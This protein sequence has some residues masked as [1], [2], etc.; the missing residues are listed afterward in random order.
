MCSNTLIKCWRPPTE[1]D[2]GMHADETFNNVGAHPVY[3]TTWALPRTVRQGKW[4]LATC[5]SSCNPQHQKK[6]DANRRRWLVQVVKFTERR[7]RVILVSVK[8]PDAGQSAASTKSANNAQVQNGFVRSSTVSFH[9]K[10][11]NYWVQ[12][13]STAEANP[14]VGRVLQVEADAAGNQT[15]VI[16]K[17][18][19]FGFQFSSAFP[20]YQR[21]DETERWSAKES[22][23]AN[24]TGF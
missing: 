12:T 14:E 22:R 8:S 13:S 15:L 5:H 21:T 24:K 17:W 6:K 10:K 7:E 4:S 2:L 19:F 3:A 20:K 23:R 16:E 9:H 11:T 18:R 1:G